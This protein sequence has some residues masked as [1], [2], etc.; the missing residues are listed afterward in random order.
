MR[1]SLLA[2]LVAIAAVASATA[3]DARPRG[4]AGFTLFQRGRDR[5]GPA[6]LL[7]LEAVLASVARQIPGHH[8]DANG[9]FP[10]GGRW[11]YRIKWLTPDGR[12]L[13][14]IADAQ[15]GQILDVR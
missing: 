14:V 10:R 13:I 15:T 7:P 1:K 2:L 5:G 9:P 6:Q 8:L 12:V 4:E 3:A 11:I